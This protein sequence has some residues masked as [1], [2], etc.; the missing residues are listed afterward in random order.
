MAETTLTGEGPEDWCY[1]A[2]ESR[3][4]SAAGSDMTLLR[5]LE[6]VWIHFDGNPACFANMV[7]GEQAI[8]DFL[9][10]PPAAET[11]A[12]VLEEARAYL[13]GVR[14]PGRSTWLALELAPDHPPVY[15][16]WWRVNGQNPEGCQ[17]PGP[18]SAGCYGGSP[19]T[20]RRGMRA[21]VRPGTVELLVGVSVQMNPTE[22]QAIE[23]KHTF[24]IQPHVGLRVQIVFESATSAR[25]ELVVAPMPTGSGSS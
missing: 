11:P 5:S 24:D 23:L 25:A 8:E 7:D 13:R 17:L 6:L 15:G 22:Q 14:T 12:N 3:C 9:V 19:A 10:G 1:D 18:E 21:L 16:T 4:W 2:L 20:N